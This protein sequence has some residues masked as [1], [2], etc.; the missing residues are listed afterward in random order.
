[1]ELEPNEKAFR[2]EFSSY[3]EKNGHMRL[4]KFYGM[5]FATSEEDAKG[6]MK[7]NPEEMESLVISEH[8]LDSRQVFLAGG[9]YL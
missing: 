1:M 7:L 8:P 9:I 4:A 6:R 3:K 2:F 5:V